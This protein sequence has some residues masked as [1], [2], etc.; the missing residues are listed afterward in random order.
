[1]ADFYVITFDAE[2]D[3]RSRFRE[4]L[5]YAGQQDGWILV[6][7]EISP[8]D[9]PLSE[10]AALLTQQSAKALLDLVSGMPVKGRA[11]FIADQVRGHWIPRPGWTG[12]VNS[13]VAQ[14]ATRTCDIKLE[15]QTSGLTILARDVL[16]GCR[17]EP[18]QTIHMFGRLDTFDSQMAEISSIRYSM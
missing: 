6:R 17:L 12:R 16:D 1:V 5:T 8:E 18:G 2:F 4:I 9:W 10:Y 11:S 15:E 13:I 7:F 14:K 3:E